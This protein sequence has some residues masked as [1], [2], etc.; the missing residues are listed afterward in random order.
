VI[1]TASTY[2]YLASSPL[3]IVPSRTPGLIQHLSPRDVNPAIKS[4]R[5]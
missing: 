1:A 4:R 5:P 2:R 3:N